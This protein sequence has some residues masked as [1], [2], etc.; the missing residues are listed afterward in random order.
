[1]LVLVLLRSVMVV[2][3]IHSSG[4]DVAV[5]A[6]VVVSAD[7]T[8]KGN[9]VKAVVGRKVQHIRGRKFAFF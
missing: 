9:G 1:M 5:S 6:A 2:V 7:I 4:D 3:V 8:V